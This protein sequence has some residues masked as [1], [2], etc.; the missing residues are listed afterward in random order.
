MTPFVV[1]LGDGSEAILPCSVPDLKFYILIFDF[2]EF[3]FVVNTLLLKIGLPIVE[4]WLP[5]ND[6][7]T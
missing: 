7:S 6:S 2:Y 4:M 3:C 1:V 5:V